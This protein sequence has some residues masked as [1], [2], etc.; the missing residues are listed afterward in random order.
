MFAWGL[1]EPPSPDEFARTTP[2]IAP[3]PAGTARPR[4]S[5]TI[6]TYNCAD[7]LERT[8]ASVLA[9]D[10]GADA[11]EIVVVDDCSTR[12]DPAAIA[13]AVGHG[14]VAFR[15]N[16]QNLGPTATFNACVGRARGRWVH[17]LHGDDMVLPGFYAECDRIVDAH[18]DVVM[19]IGPVVTIDP[20]DRWTAVIGP[21][22]AV[23]ARTSTTSWRSG[24]RS[25][26]RSSRA[27]PCVATPTSA[28][29]SRRSSATSPIGTCGSGSASSAPWWCTMR[30]YGLYA[31]T[32]AD[33]GSTSAWRRTS[34]KPTSARA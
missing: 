6:P 31:S 18:P 2:P 17:L 22:R 26:S 30:P 4:W 25:S 23:R 34:R 29:G 15:R 16:P 27:S 8:L 5:V 13:A 9:Q 28:A 7:L 20:E 12:D 1:P 19:I 10:P 3:V 24:R 32:A 14:R 33:T 11:M 21:D